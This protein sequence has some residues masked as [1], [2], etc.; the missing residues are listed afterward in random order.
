MSRVP[1]FHSSEKTDVYHVCDKCTV[2]N[3]IE[4]KNVRQG[5]GKGRLCKLC[6][7]LIDKGEC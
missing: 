1:P 5:K 3:N 7:Q 6:K 2:G 4:K